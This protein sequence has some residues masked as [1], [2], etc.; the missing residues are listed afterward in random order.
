[1][2]MRTMMAT[3]TR[4]TSRAVF[5]GSIGV[6]TLEARIHEM[7]WGRANFVP[8]SLRKKQ[9]ASQ[10]EHRANFEE[11]LADCGTL[12]TISRL[13]EPTRGGPSE[14]IAPR[15]ARDYNRARGVIR[16]KTSG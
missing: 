13:H 15:S 7:G 11:A 6:G 10:A 14:L 5:N 4:K 9:P 2:V 1:M 3:K 12:Q 16:L 8:R